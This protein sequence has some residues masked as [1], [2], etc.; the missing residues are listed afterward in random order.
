MQFPGPTHH[1]PPATRLIDVQLLS[2]STH[3]RPFAFETLSHLP[4][5]NQIVSKREGSTATATGRAFAV[6]KTVRIL[7][8]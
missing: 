4:I 3:S 2:L 1:Q 6:G 7:K 5:L 8:F